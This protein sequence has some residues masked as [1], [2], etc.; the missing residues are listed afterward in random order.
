[1]TSEDNSIPS[2][3]S[4]NGHSSD[5]DLPKIRVELEGMSPFALLP[6]AIAAGI[7]KCRSPPTRI[8]AIPISHPINVFGLS[9]DD[10]QGI[11][12]H[13]FDNRTLA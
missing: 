8:P 6:Y 4:V 12:R 1:M 9:S 5:H 3:T 11:Q 10:P 7:V 13:T 2:V